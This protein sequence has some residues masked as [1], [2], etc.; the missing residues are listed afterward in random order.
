[1]DLQRV[2][3]SRGAASSIVNQPS[4]A[5]TVFLF[6]DIFYLLSAG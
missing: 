1:V 5:A 2:P 3:S 6:V 4:I